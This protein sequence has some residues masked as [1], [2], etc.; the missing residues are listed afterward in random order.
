MRD[1]RGSDGETR[2]ERRHHDCG[3][4]HTRR[5]R[6]AWRVLSSLVSL[7][8]PLL[9][10]HR[11]VDQRP[12]GVARRDARDSRLCLEPEARGEDFPLRVRRCTALRPGDARRPGDTLADPRHRREPD[13]PRRQPR[14]GT[15]AA[16]HAGGEH[17][18]RRY[19]LAPDRPCARRIAACRRRRARTDG[20][21]G[22][23]DR[24]AA[25]AVGRAARAGDHR[26]AILSR[27]RGRTAG[28]A[29]LA[30]RAPNGRGR[31]TSRW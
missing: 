29:R 24:L 21:D 18:R 7:S 3:Y 9:S 4:V 30:A 31:R 10:L 6:R 8:G 5:C 17:D 14:R 1:E 19:E 15:A 22:E 28:S 26:L 12:H 20:C 2:D 23:R 16:S 25:R 13:D 11:S 27:A